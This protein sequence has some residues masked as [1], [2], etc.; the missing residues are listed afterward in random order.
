MHRR[1]ATTCLAA[2]TVEGTALALECVDDVE[3]G[4]GLA[5]CVLGVGDCVTNDTLEEGLEDTTCLFV[6]HWSLLVYEG[7]NQRTARLRTG[8]DTLDTTTTCET[9][10]GGLGDTLDVVSQDLT[11][12]LGTALSEAFAAFTACIDVSML[13]N[14]LLI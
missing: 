2:E 3:G 7:V 6:D 11:M 13:N 1:L 14:E 10:N 8:R 5:L 9:A 4:D 12:A